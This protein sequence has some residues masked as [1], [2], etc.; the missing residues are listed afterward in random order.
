MVSRIRESLNAF[1]M[2]KDNPIL[3]PVHISLAAALSIGF[4]DLAVDILSGQTDGVALGS[5]V[6]AL[7]VTIG[8]FFLFSTVLWSLVVSRMGR[9]FKLRDMPLAISFAL[10]IVAGVLLLLAHPPQLK[11][12]TAQQPGP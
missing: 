9:F 11:R 12:V 5:L 8:L 7:A 3:T 1:I 10:F 4:I 2:N 6:M